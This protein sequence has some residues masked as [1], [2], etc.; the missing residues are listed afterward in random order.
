MNLAP[1]QFALMLLLIL[2]SSTAAL[3]QVS[4]KGPMQK[5]VPAADTLTEP[6]INDPFPQSSSTDSI[7]VGKPALSALISITRTTDPFGLDSQGA[8]TISLP[9]AAQLTI[10]NNL[11]IGISRLDEQ[12]RKLLYWASLGKFLPDINLM[13]NYNYVKGQANLPFI[14]LSPTGLHL[15]NP[16]IVAG[17]GF[18]YHAFRG[19]SILFG[20][21][22]SKS[23]YRA[24]QNYR[25]ATVND[26]LLQSAKYYYDLLLQQAILAVRISAVRTSEEQLKLNNDLHDGGKATMLE[27]YQAETQLSQ[28]RQNL[29]DQQIA[30][31]DAA[32]K[33]SSIFEY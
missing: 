27:V 28:D 33:I 29:I 25:Q 22:Q 18:T 11:D 12:S 20:A 21:M 3:A 7:T 6:T 9:E 32:N 15:N 24:A 13:Y 16:I 10:D 26:A 14:G 17:A 2:H 4:L 23:N 30:R 5:S 8:R 19:G 31:R 1:T